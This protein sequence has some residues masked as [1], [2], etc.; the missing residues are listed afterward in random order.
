[1]ANTRLPV[2]TTPTRIELGQRCHRRHVIA[3]I[4]ERGRWYSPS[5]EFGNV[6]HSGVGAWWNTGSMVLALEA[7][8]HEWQRRFEKRI[9]EPG[10]HSFELAVD[11]LEYYVKEAKLPSNSFVELGP[12]KPLCIE[13]RY[14][15]DIEGYRM[16]FQIDRALYN[17]ANDHLVI[18]DL[19]TASRADK[20]WERTWQRSIQMKLYKLAAKQVFKIEH[21]DIVIEG[22]EK[23]TKPRLVEVVC[24]EWSDDMLDEA[25]R[26]FVRIAEED[27]QLLRAASYQRFP[28]SLA[29]SDPAELV[30]DMDVLMNMALTE[31]SFNYEDC[32]AY[33]YECPFLPLCLANPDERVGMLKSDYIE[34]ETDY[35]S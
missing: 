13:D 18:V 11:L 20:V 15:A 22:L 1:M 17:T 21:V 30:L 35:V 9:T 31:T 33:H 3:D 34:V 4:L 28:S 29:S 26:E 5:A 32:Y 23:G 27:E 10:K 16:S 24:P 25:K 19:K 12:W 14:E 7:M 8:Q 2:I 6:L